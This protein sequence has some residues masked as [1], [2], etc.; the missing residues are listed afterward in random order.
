MAYLVEVNILFL[1]AADTKTCVDISNSFLNCFFKT[2]FTKANAEYFKCGASAFPCRQWWRDK[3]DYLPSFL[4]LEV[5]LTGRQ[6][7]EGD[8]KKILLWQQ[9]LQIVNRSGFTQWTTQTRTLQLIFYF[10]PHGQW[11][12]N[13]LKNKSPWTTFALHPDYIPAFPYSRSFLPTNE[14]QHSGMQIDTGHG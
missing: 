12:N 4:R 1:S 13:E 7:G 3:L 11:K 9:T 8:E 6:M 2:R 14:D 10:Q 5:A